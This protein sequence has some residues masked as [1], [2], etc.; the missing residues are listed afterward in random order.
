VVLEGPGPID[1]VCQDTARVEVLGDE[2]FELVDDG[3]FNT[4]KGGCGRG[5]G[6]GRWFWGFTWDVSGGFYACLGTFGVTFRQ[7]E[8]L[9]VL[10]FFLGVILGTLQVACCRKRVLLIVVLEDLLRVMCFEKGFLPDVVLGFQ[11]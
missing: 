10:W 11:M 5:C 2:L 6:T 4:G 8:L 7:V 9:A 1:I 3:H